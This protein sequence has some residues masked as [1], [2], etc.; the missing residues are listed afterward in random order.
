M[1]AEIE[2]N[3]QRGLLS[4]REG[5]YA[6]RFY[7]TRADYKRV[8]DSASKTHMDALV[9]SGSFIGKGSA[10]KAVAI[11]PEFWAAQKQVVS[12]E[13]LARKLGVGPEALASLGFNANN[14]I[15][16][17]DALEG[18]ESMNDYG[19]SGFCRIQQALGGGG[20][21]SHELA[22]RNGNGRGHNDFRSEFR[23][24]RFGRP[25]YYQ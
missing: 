3:V 7:T 17:H 15:D 9:L 4:R 11:L 10:T 12:Q 24:D 25:I 20:L 19:Q 6:K 1:L 21:T 2:N 22:Y 23:R 16:R 18:L 13:A 8:R 14:V 5:D